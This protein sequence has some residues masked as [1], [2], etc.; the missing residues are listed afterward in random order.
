[1]TTRHG[2]WPWLPPPAFRPQWMRDIRVPSQQPRKQVSPPVGEDESDAEAGGKVAHTKPAIAISATANSIP[3]IEDRAGTG[4][5]QERV[6][7]VIR[8]PAEYYFL[9]SD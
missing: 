9:R 4:L 5:Q 1:M 3:T 8:R 2:G 7:V 6:R